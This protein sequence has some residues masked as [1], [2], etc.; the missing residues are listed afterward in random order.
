MESWS[1]MFLLNL[2]FLVVARAMTI[3]RNAGIST[4]FSFQGRTLMSAVG[5]NNANYI[6][7]F[8]QQTPLEWENVIKE[9]LSMWLPTGMTMREMVEFCKHATVDHQF[10]FIDNIEGKCY[11]SKLTKSQVNA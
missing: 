6:L 7:I 2:W 1:E 10:F 5:R 4:V 8:K 3:Y 11:L 9:F